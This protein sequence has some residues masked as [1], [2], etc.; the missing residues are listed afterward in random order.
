MY[1]VMCIFKKI[2]IIR[3]T[4]VEVNSFIIVPSLIFFYFCHKK[5]KLTYV[6]KYGSSTSLMLID[7][8]ITFVVNLLKNSVTMV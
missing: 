2:S 5:T 8:F 6:G 3:K 1:K 7:Y 4:F